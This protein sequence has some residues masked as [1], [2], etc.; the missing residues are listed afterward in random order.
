MRFTTA[1]MAFVGR[2]I[3]DTRKIAHS[4]CGTAVIPCGVVRSP[5]VARRIRTAIQVRAWSTCKDQ[6]GAQHRGDKL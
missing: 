3:R 2:R 4:S 6:E 1:A 5:A